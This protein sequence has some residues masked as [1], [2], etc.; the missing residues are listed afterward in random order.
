MQ[1]FWEDKTWILLLFSLN[2]SPQEGSKIFRLPR[3]NILARE[4]SKEEINAILSEVSYVCWWTQLSTYFLRSTKISTTMIITDAFKMIA[5]WDLGTWPSFLQLES[6]VP[7]ELCV[8]VG[9]SQREQVDV[10]W[11][12]S[13]YYLLFLN[14]FDPRDQVLVWVVTDV[15]K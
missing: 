13:P 3:Y 11:G 6:W 15:T 10:S 5:Q 14:I 8:S 9:G 1:I 2:I 4:K 7:A 12:I